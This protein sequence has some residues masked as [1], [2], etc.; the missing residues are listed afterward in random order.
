MN[1]DKQGFYKN[2][3]ILFIGYRDVYENKVEFMLVLIVQ[4]NRK[5]YTFRIM[6]RFKKVNAC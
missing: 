5:K 1:L 4:V 3:R 6:F 2:N